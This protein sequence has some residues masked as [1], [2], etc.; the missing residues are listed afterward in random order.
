MPLVEIACL[1]DDF[2]HSSTHCGA[3]LTFTLV[4]VAADFHLPAPR[5]SFIETVCLVAKTSAGLVN[6]VSREVQVTLYA[7]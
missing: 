4:D 7:G 1:P 2:V 3:L 6:Y 5:H